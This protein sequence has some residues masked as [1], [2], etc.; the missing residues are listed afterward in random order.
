MVLFHPQATG[1]L[2][3]YEF[4][5]VMVNFPQGAPTTLLGYLELLFDLQYFR[6]RGGG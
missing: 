1:L 6:W 5:P 4:R 2:S 3:F